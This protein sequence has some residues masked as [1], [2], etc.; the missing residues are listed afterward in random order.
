MTELM[1][2]NINLVKEDKD[3]PIDNQCLVDWLDDKVDALEMIRQIVTATDHDC[4]MGRLDERLGE[5]EMQI[6][7]C[8]W[9]SRA[10]ME[11]HIYQGIRHL[12]NAVGQEL[13]VEPFQEGES[14]VGYFMYRGVK[15]F[16]LRNIGEEFR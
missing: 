7:S 3:V 15:F 2:R 8:A 11:C 4:Y 6:E 14:E 13:T 10:V 16:E 5:Y 9:N 12:A 1:L